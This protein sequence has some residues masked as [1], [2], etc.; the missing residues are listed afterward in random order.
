[1]NLLRPPTNVVFLAGFVAY[2]ATRHVHLSR[3]GKPETVTRRVDGLEKLLLALVLLGSLLVPVLY[4]FTPLLN[5]ANY[6]QPRA[7]PWAGLPVM[8]AALWLFHRSHAD[9]GRNWSV[10]LEV[11]KDHE[12]VTRG[13]YRYVRHPMYASIWLF[14]LAQALFLP[15]WLA[16][17]GSLAPF[18]LMYAL[19][20]AREE[21][22]M[23]DTFGDAYRDYMNRTPRLIPLPRCV[24]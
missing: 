3:V 10:S 1:V 8:L 24:G 15:N 12:L 20:V 23:L 2:L 22:L 14:S 9:L 5:F 16:G 7:L 19:R 21:R 17:F 4:L 11:R 18:A 13:V 6:A